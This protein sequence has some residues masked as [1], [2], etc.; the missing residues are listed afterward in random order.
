M[1]IDEMKHTWS[2]FASRQISSLNLLRQ[3]STSR[4]A[5]TPSSL[6]VNERTGAMVVFHALPASA[7]HCRNKLKSIPIFE[8]GH[9]DI[10]PAVLTT[11][12][13]WRCWCTCLPPSA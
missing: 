7:R 10:S 5:L 1:R 6:S 11:R 13:D 3:M 8:R 4:S 9:T 12:A 2:F